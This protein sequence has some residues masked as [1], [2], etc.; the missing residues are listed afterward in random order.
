MLILNSVKLAFEHLN[1]VCKPNDRSSAEMIFEI[2]KDVEPTEL[3]N[4][5][6][7]QAES[8]WI[9]KYFTFLGAKKR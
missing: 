3:K 9:R 1:K 8:F 4:R 7:N 6:A 2:A 5:K